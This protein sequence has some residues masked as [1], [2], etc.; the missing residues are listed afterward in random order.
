MYGSGN[1]SECLLFYGDGLGVISQ[2]HE[3]GG[4]PGKFPDAADQ[5][6]PP[7]GAF[8]RTLRARRTFGETWRAIYEEDR[9]NPTLQQTDD[10]KNDAVRKTAYIYNVTGDWTLRLN[11]R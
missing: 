4:W 1:P 5:P 6:S 7:G 9:N 3:T 2:A 8:E 11:K 10:S